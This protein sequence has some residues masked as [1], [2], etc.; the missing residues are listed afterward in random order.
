M[1]DG[2]KARPCTVC[3][4]ETVAGSLRDS[5][6]NWCTPH[7]A[8]WLSPGARPLSLSRILGGGEY[9]LPHES[10]VVAARCTACGHVDLWT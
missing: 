9:G 1:A 10:P 5:R 4:G 8:S 2:E 3:G 7:P 6:T